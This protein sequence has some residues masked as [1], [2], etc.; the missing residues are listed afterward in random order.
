MRGPSDSFWFLLSSVQPC[1]DLY[2]DR[3]VSP[4]IESGSMPKGTQQQDVSVLSGAKNGLIYLTANDWTLIAD[5]ASRKKFEPGGTIVQ[6]GKRTYGVFLLL[7]GTAVV[8]IGMGRTP[9]LEPGQVC[10]EISCLDD[11]PATANVVA[12]DEVEAYYLDRATLD[13]L[14]ELFPHLGSRFYRSLAYSLSARLRE[15]ISAEETGGK[16]PGLE[17][18]KKTT[19]PQI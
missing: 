4:D 14:F 5:K 19:A 3:R 10:G 17:T 1:C 12:Q 6:R 11:L 16:T 9:Q 2:I 8:E 13:S 15:M 7:R 18:P